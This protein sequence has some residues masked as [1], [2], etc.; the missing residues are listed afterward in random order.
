MKINDQKNAL[1]F[2]QFI[3]KMLI[4]HKSGIKFIMLLLLNDILNDFFYHIFFN[5]FLLIVFIKK[6]LSGV[7]T[8]YS[9]WNYS[10]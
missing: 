8:P 1:Q 6:Y 4:F 5:H 2:F 7:V 3:M 9:S 10:E